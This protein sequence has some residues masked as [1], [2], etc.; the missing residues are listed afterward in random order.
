MFIQFRDFGHGNCLYEVSVHA[1]FIIYLLCGFFPLA[2]L[3]C[4][5]WGFQVS[6]R[7]HHH[8]NNNEIK[9]I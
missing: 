4:L 2:F 9:R 8:L 7:S 1:E 5:Q 6:V 3:A